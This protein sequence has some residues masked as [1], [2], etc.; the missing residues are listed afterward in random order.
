MNTRR[1]RERRAPPRAPLKASAAPM[2]L[3]ATLCAALLGC[4]GAAAERAPATPSPLPAPTRTSAEVLADSKPSDWRPVDPARTL[5]MEVAGGRVVIELA[6][7]FAPAHV[8]NVLALAAA[9]D[10][11]GLAI[12]RVQDHAVVRWAAPAGPRARGAA[13]RPHDDEYDRPAAGLPFTPL[14]DGD[15]YAP[16][17]GWSDGM[18]AGRH[19]ADGRAWVAH[20]YGVVGVGR[21]MPPDNGVGNELYVVSGHAPRHLDRNLAMV[22]RVLTGMEVLTSLPRGTGALGFYDKPEQR[23]KIAR[24]R[25]LAALP[26]AERPRLEVL[27]T[28]T[29][30][31]SDYVASRRYRGEGFFVQPT[32]RVELCNVAVPV[33]VI[34]ET[35]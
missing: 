17:V 2:A 29:A 22:G 24:I 16:E 15:V 21:D 20:C 25:P 35:R 33:R 14:P 1:L 28:D 5:L 34:G 18:P 23:V 7:A 9:G 4:A 3:T 30:T 31:W 13:A 6:P 19:G 12:V 11:D 26:E 10:V 8:A 32:G 27:R